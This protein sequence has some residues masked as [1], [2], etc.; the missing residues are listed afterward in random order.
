MTNTKRGCGSRRGVYLGVVTALAL[1]LSACGGA[2]SAGV[3]SSVSSSAP[4][5]STPTSSVASGTSNSS[6]PTASTNAVTINWTPPTENVN[7]TPLTNLA[8]YNIHYGTTS[9]NY[10]QTITVS[11]PGI[12]TYVVQNLSPGTY[13]F[14]VAAVNS[15]GT[16]SPPSSQVSATVN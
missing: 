16:E 8:G 6:A 10:T 14:V 1:A 3:A 9:G 7:D 12:A 15:A 11:N 2:G 13:Y 4:T 5:Q